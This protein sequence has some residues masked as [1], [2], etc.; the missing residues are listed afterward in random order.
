MR[1]KLLR[2]TAL[3][4]TGLAFASFDAAAAEKIHLGL[5]GY[6]NAFVAYTDE[7][8][9]VGEPGAGIRNHGVFREAEVYFLGKTTL[10]NGIAFGLNVQLE[11]ETSADQIDESYLY[12]E[13]TFGHVRV[14]SDDPVTDEMFIGAPVVIRGIGLGSPDAVYATLIND[15]GAPDTPLSISVDAEKISY[16]SPRINGFRFGLSYTPDNCEDSGC[17]GTGLRPK[18]TAS[19]QSEILEIAGTYEDKWGDTDIAFYGGYGTADLEVPVAGSEDRKQWAIGASASV[20][21]WTFGGSF[22][23][24]NQGTSAAN[25]ERRDYSLGLLYA[26]GPWSYGI[27]YASAVVEVGAGLGD[28][29]TNGLQVGGSYQLGPGV[30]VTGGLTFWQANDNLNARSVENRAVNAVL[31]TILNF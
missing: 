8:S 2:S 24:D 29:E 10:D 25:T 20:A 14:G 9:S 13:G 3:A 4:V 27:E 18:N 7:E 16:Y 23:K 1:D 21:G 31:G 26:D 30:L 15:A 28:D 22:K 12:V 19:Q 6:F 11:G 5:G 17:G